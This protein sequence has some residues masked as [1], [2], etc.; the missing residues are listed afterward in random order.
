MT[1]WTAANSTLS[2]SRHDEGD[3]GDSTQTQLS[4]HSK[5]REKQTETPEAG[6]A[7]LTE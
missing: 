4:T 1:G 2:P 5:G 6:L 7:R 3:F